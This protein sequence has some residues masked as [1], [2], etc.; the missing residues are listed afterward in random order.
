[1]KMKKTLFVLILTALIFNI[2]AEFTDEP[3]SPEQLER[4]KT[5]ILEPVVKNCHILF[6]ISFVLKICF[7]LKVNYCTPVAP[8]RSGQCC[9]KI[10]EGLCNHLFKFHMY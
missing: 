6:I 9:R 2:K 1:M 3:V 7:I 5:D 4:L 8:C 10:A